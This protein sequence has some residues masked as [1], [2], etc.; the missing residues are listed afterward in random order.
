MSDNA[1]QYRVVQGI[2]QWDPREGEAAGKKVRNCT[3]RS[4]GLKEQSVLVSL[5]L[6]PSHAGTEIKQGDV[7]TAEGVFTR[8]TAPDAEGNT[9][10]YNNLSVSRLFK[11]GS[12]DA[13]VRDDA[14]TTSDEPD[15]TDEDDDI[16]Y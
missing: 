3:I 16:P 14:A 11:H 2:V 7:V 12:A 1:K 5:T 15:E 10:T 13:G 4:S 6:W 8:S 9:R